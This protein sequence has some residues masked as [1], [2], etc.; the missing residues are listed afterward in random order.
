MSKANNSYLRIEIRKQKCETFEWET[1]CV[2]DIKLGMGFPLLLHIPMTKSQIK[3]VFWTKE[4][5]KWTP[6]NG[7]VQANL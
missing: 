2:E 7:K 6:V 1:K 4:G 5:E 3:G